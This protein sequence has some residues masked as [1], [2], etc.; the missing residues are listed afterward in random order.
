M[1]LPAV[2]R[3][4]VSPCCHPAVGQHACLCSLRG[5]QDSDFESPT[6]AYLFAG[7]VQL[8][9]TALQEGRWPATLSVQLRFM[10]G[11]ADNNR[12]YTRST[13]FPAPSLASVPP[14]AAASA[15][16]AGGAQRQREAT[17]QPPPTGDGL[18]YDAEAHAR[19][20][21]GGGDGVSSGR[22]NS[23][24]GGGVASRNI[25][26]GGS[27]GGR[28]QLAEHAA[29]NRA[30]GA[31]PASHCCQ[32]QPRPVAVVW[33]AHRQRLQRVCA[34]SK[35]ESCGSA[36]RAATPAGQLDAVCACEEKTRA[37]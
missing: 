9:C 28:T 13:A 36:H 33:C 30:V 8:S 25:N 37:G 23:S 5:A 6:M 31:A 15:P 12:Y 32:H 24:D 1:Q 34:P 10:G 26:G 22:G 2:G 19:G 16:S 29:S 4:M 20:S 18:P 14:P 3:S 21:G 17:L 27:A 35:A 7:I 11:G